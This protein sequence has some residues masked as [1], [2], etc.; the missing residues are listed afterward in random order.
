MSKGATER[1]RLVD[2]WSSLFLLITLL[3]TGLV[4]AALAPF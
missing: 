2:V 4:T 1:R 3:G